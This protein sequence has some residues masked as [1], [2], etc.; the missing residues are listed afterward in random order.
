MAIKDDKVA[1]FLK[2]QFPVIFWGLLIAVV[3]SIPK[4][5][6]PI[7]S[8][9]YA[10]KAAHFLEYAIFAYLMCRAL[11]YSSRPHHLSRAVIISIVFCAV[12]AAG[13]ELHQLFIPGRSK[14]LTDFIADSLGILSALALFNFRHGG[15]AHAKESF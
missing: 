11:F 14:S 1:K 12:F 4:I 10:D 2:Y 13:D 7:P 5:S 9:P 6:Q 3:S 15:N 8:I